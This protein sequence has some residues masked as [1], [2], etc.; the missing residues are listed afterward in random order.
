[1]E[2]EPIGSYNEFFSPH[3]TWAAASGN[4][5]FPKWPRPSGVFEE[6]T[7]CDGAVG[8]PDVTKESLYGLFVV[9]DR[10]QGLSRAICLGAR[11]E[12]VKVICENES[13]WVGCSFELLHDLL[14]FNSVF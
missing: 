7:H 3:S 6:Y 4:R 8:G 10:K 9:S 12:N 5:K 11:C 13:F 14:P 1:M 2:F